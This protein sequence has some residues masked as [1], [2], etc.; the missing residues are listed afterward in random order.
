[1][2]MKVIRGAKGQLSREECVKVWESIGMDLDPDKYT[3][4]AIG[5]VSNF[6]RPKLR[7]IKCKK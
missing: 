4:I 2:Q 7:V 6:K 1:M 3:I 5:G